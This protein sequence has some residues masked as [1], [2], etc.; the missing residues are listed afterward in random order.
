[1]K[2]SKETERGRDLCCALHPDGKHL[3]LFTDE[4]QIGCFTIENLEMISEYNANGIPY[5]CMALDQNGS[6][7]FVVLARGS[8]IFA[9]VF[10]SQFKLRIFSQCLRCLG[11]GIG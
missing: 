4:S 8:W 11:K 3:F 5:K 1:M 10:F 2:L 7:L 6:N 9:Q